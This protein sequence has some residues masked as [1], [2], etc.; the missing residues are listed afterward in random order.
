MNTK[1]GDHLGPSAIICPLVPVSHVP[2]I[3]TILTSSQ[4]PP[5]SHITA[6]NLERHNLNQEQMRLPG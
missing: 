3:W 5:K 2:P 4:G 6:H 1:R